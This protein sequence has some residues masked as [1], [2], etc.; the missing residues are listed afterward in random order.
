[1]RFYVDAMIKDFPYYLKSKVARPWTQKLLMIS[2]SAKALNDE[3]LSYLCDESN[4]FE[5]MWMDVNHAISILS[6]R[7]EESNEGDW[8]KLLHLMNFLKNTRDDI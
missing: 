3:D 6:S 7:V 4:V 8:K 1:M 2:K 5:Q